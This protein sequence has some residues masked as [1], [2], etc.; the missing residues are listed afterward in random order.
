M[1][2]MFKQK[3]GTP[4][5]TWSGWW[6]TYPPEKYEFVNGKDDI[7]YMKWTK[8]FETTNQSL[9]HEPMVSIY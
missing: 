3:L 5:K 9:V 6:L 4:R 1:F 2:G 8:M 7:P